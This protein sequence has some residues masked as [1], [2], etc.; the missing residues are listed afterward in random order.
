MYTYMYRVQWLNFSCELLLL[1]E[2]ESVK[3]CT[4]MSG[5]RTKLFILY[6]KVPNLIMKLSLV[7]VIHVLSYESDKLPQISMKPRSD[8]II[9]P[10]L[11]LIIIT[12]SPKKVR[13]ETHKDLHSIVESDNI[14][15]IRRHQIF[16]Q[17]EK[18]SLEIWV[19]LLR[20]AGITNP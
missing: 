1:C 8:E 10:T 14:N 11:V 18:D 2:T 15:S 20:P 4:H 17:Q 12:F 13:T 3:S 16:I 6:F 9:C 7:S 5:I 19:Q